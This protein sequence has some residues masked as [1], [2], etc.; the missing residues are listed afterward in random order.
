MIICFTNYIWS[1]FRIIVIWD[2]WYWN[3]V[4]FMP[5]LNFYQYFLLLSSQGIFVQQDDILL[6]IL[7][8][9][10]YMILE[11]V[12]TPNIHL[13]IILLE[14]HIYY[15]MDKDYMFLDLI[16]YFCKD[17]RSSFFCLL[18]FIKRN[19][20]IFNMLNFIEFSFKLITNDFLYINF[21]STIFLYNITIAILNYDKGII[22]DF[23]LKIYKNIKHI[24]IY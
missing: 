10:Q 19:K 24:I 12:C 15:N 13:H 5:Y 8:H 6:C 9:N 4:Y 22:Y 14:I 11:L 16:W 20:I 17:L 7:E 1:M 3:V 2:S 23:F 21:I 18:N